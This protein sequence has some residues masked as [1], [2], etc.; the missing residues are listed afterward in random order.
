MIGRL[1]N[2]VSDA[3]APSEFD[4]KFA[5]PCAAAALDHHDD[6]HLLRGIIDI[7]RQRNVDRLRTRTLIEVL[8]ASESRPSSGQFQR[9]AAKLAKRLRPLLIRPK[10]IRFNDGPAKGYEREY[11]E[12]ALIRIAE[13]AAPEARLS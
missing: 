7:F 13:T 3:I 12:K 8:S 2:A 1:L 4:L 5:S 11:F 10:T 9:D 6:I